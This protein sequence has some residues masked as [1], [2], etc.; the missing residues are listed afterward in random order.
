MLASWCCSKSSQM[1]W[2]KQCVCACACVCVCVCVCVSVCAQLLSH[3]QHF[4][5][6]W[7]VALQAL[8]FRRFPRQ[9]YWGGL[10]FHPPEDFPDPRVE[11]AYITVS[12]RSRILKSCHL[13]GGMFLL[14]ALGSNP[15]LCL[16]QL[17]EAL[18]S[19][20]VD[21]FCP[22]YQLYR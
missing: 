21:S 18:N 2:L 8:L 20:S 4:A 1:C 5:S 19:W 13:L 7:T 9:E 22:Q 10:P 6:P 16:S 11:Y 12:L 17:Q 14:E 15:F 3:V